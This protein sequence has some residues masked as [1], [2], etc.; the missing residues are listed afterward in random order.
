MQAE[1]GTQYIAYTAKYHEV[2][3]MYRSEVSAYNIVDASVEYGLMLGIYYSHAI[4]WADPDAVGPQGNSW[5]FD[6][7][8]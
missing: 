1:A 6:P 7:M 4:D 5:D 8:H 3:A 2:L